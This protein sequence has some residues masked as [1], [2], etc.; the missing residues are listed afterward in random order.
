VSN[1]TPTS[2]FLYKTRT[3]RTAFWKKKE[4]EKMIRKMAMSQFCCH[5][6]KTFVDLR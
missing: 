1:I 6:K 2:T 4:L 3:Q 5:S